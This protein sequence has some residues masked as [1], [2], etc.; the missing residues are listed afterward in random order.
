MHPYLRESVSGTRPA[1]G[2][3]GVRGSLALRVRTRTA[4]S[5]DRGEL[6][7]LAARG[8]TLSR[9]I[10]ISLLRLPPPNHHHRPITTTTHIRAMRRCIYVLPASLARAAA[11]APLR[12]RATPVLWLSRRTHV[13][14]DG[15]HV[16]GIDPVTP[17][18]Y[19]KIANEYLEALADTIEELRDDYPDVDVELTQ[20]VMTLTVAEGKTYVINKMPPNQ[21][22]WLSSPIS[23]P[24]RYDLIGGRW[25]TLRDN[26]LLTDLL[27]EELKAELG[28]E[29]D[30]A[31]EQ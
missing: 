12:P 29:V 6:W 15:A 13:T 22:I 20:G 2:G 14:T 7:S 27:A 28:P 9:A 17:G 11:R 31:L 5:Q 8:T 24:K 4:H 25:V 26:T 19:D 18:Q 30:L 10:V 16:T 1:V 23:G 3:S 21:Q